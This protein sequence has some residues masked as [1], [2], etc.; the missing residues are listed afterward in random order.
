MSHPL[1]FTLVASHMYTG[2]YIMYVSVLLHEF[3]LDS[4][5]AQIL[6][7]RKTDAF[8]SKWQT[9]IVFFLLF[10]LFLIMTICNIDVQRHPSFVG[11]AIYI[12]QYCLK[13]N[14]NSNL[15]FYKRAI[16]Y[17]GR[18]WRGETFSEKII[19]NRIFFNVIR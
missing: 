3:V 4:T 15:I 6:R 13:I 12:P 5:S 8:F 16:I 10:V 18:S 14:F 19:F 7:E 17:V 1:N 11:M 2:A 9:C